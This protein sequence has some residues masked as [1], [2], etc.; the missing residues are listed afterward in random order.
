MLQQ[1]CVLWMRKPSA[2][3]QKSRFGKE[4]KH[5]ER[6]H[7]PDWWSTRV[8]VKVGYIS[9]CDGFHPFSPCEGRPIP[10]VHPAGAPCR[11]GTIRGPWWPP[12]RWCWQAF[13]DR[14][15]NGFDPQIRGSS[16]SF[17]T[18]ACHPFGCEVLCM[19]FGVQGKISLACHSQNFS[20]C[21]LRL[22][23]SFKF[24]RDLPHSRNSMVVLC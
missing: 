12:A 7:Q 9:V 14:H 15:G 23:D 3:N 1:G 6:P 5:P 2:S 20:E 21:G 8:P 19:T 17:T 18:G 11:E 22:F 13:F 10:R 4:D 24:T 16:R